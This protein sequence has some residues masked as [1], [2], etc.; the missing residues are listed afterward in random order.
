MH[1]GLVCVLT[2]QRGRERRQRG[3]SVTQLS[4]NKRTQ[5][6]H[7]CAVPMTSTGEI[8]QDHEMQCVPWTLREISR[9]PSASAPDKHE[10][11]W[12][13]KTWQR[14]SSGKR[15]CARPHQSHPA[16]Q[17]LTAWGYLPVATT[18]VQWDGQSPGTARLNVGVRTH[19]DDIYTVTDIQTRV[20][21]HL[22]N[23]SHLF[24]F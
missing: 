21:T 1:A 19:W 15:N 3:T 24:F 7:L 18:G 13:M 16:P 17:P 22:H 11:T 5:T 4:R 20:D 8:P 10:V 6:H 12:L 23:A 14:R 9:P 2:W